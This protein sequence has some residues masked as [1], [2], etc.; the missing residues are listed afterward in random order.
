MLFTPFNYDFF[1]VVYD[2]YLFKSYL[3]FIFAQNH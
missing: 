1:N 3:L 2:F